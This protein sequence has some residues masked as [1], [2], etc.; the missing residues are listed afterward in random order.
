MFG[1]SSILRRM[2]AIA[3]A[4]VASAALLTGVADARSGNGG[5]AGS[6]GAK[7]FTAPPSTNT[8]PKS[9]APIDKSFTQNSGAKS[10]T[11]ATAAAAQPSRFGS[12]A[13]NLLL[14]G[15]IGA[16]LASLF[17]AGA[18][19]GVLGFLLQGL[20]IGGLVFLAYNFFRNRFGAPKLAT[21]TAGAAPQVAPAAYQPA[22]YSAAAASSAPALNIGE[23]DFNSFERLLGEVQGA[24]GRADTQALGHLV[25]P[26]MLSYFAGD[27]AGN[28]KNGQ[29]NELGQPKL[30]QGDLA[31][32]W[33]EAD[34]EYASVA[35]KYALTDAM[36]DIKT[37]RVV[38]GS[39]T[40]PDEVTEIWTFRRPLNGA[41]QQ[42]E[43]SAIQ[44]A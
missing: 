32:S 5:S 28:A 26:E 40:A 17:G 9:A 34:G 24:Y 29:R 27:L 43:L 15:L 7:T 30:L 33:R 11:A 2:A 38:S 8:A 14:G 13:R 10:A 23:A 1:T 35:M 18:L 4:V 41:T 25:T 37:G 19:A 16:G 36:V 3:L 20:L 44:Q 12:M 6:R 31:E 21:A 22:A 42:W 39:T